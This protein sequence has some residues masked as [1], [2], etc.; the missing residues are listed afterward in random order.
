MY[1]YS[2]FR[3][4]FKFI[5]RYRFNKKAEETSGNRYCRH[6]SVRRQFSVCQVPMD[7]GKLAAVDQCLPAKHSCNTTALH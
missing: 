1:Y 5:P 7:I 3:K 2:L 6:F 4:L